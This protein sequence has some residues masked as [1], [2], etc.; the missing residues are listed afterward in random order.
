MISPVKMNLK[1]SLTWA[2]LKPHD[3]S[4]LQNELKTS[5]HPNYV[6]VPSGKSRIAAD[7]LGICFFMCD[8]S[9]LFP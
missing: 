8:F 6:H 5:P 4:G 9:I 1:I 7:I 2:H 3:M